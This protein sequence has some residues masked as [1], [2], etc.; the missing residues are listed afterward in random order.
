MN[1]IFFLKAPVVTVPGAKGI[2]LDP[3]ALG[4]ACGGVD[5]YC[6][7]AYSQMW[8]YYGGAGNVVA[9]LRKKYGIDG[10]VSFVA[11]SAA[12]GFMNPLLNADVDRA[13]IAAVILM[14]AS[15][16]GGK[17]G[18]VKAAQ[19]A[20]AGKLTLVSATSNT[21]GDESWQTVLQQAGIAGSPTSPVPPMPAPKGGVTRAGNLWTYRYDGEPPHWKFGELQ[22]PVIDAYLGPNA[23]G[24]GTTKGSSSWW[25]A[26]LAVGA[27]VGAYYWWT[28]RN[29]DGRSI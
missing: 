12:H 21:G 11:F 14:D 8:S 24:G 2:A 1:G 4:F 22:K 26:L 17:T 23:P 6:S 7:T 5:K 3:V 20:A 10:T 13:D 29:R 9:A 28:R 16:G 27:G 15:F 19:D 25:P 18:Y